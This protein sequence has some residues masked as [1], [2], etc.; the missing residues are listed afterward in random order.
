MSYNRW[1]YGYSNPIKYLDPSGHISYDRNKAITYARKYDGNTPLDLTYHSENGQDYLLFDYSKDGGSL[2]T[3]FASY[4]LWEGGVRDTR[5]D[6]TTVENSNYDPSWWSKEAIRITKDPNDPTI[7]NAIDTRYQVN[8]QTTS[9]SKTQKF[10]DFLMNPTNVNVYVREVIRADYILPKYYN[11]G[12]VTGANDTDWENKLKDAYKS[13]NVTV[14]DLVFYD[15]SDDSPYNQPGWDHVAVIDGWGMQT[16][17][18]EISLFSSIP[19]QSCDWDV[20]KPRVI[21]KSG[22]IIY[23]PGTVTHFGT[24]MDGGRSIDN[25]KSTI[26]SIAVLHLQ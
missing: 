13:R 10:F 7:D 26:K 5:P 11:N 23:E 25:T 14:G 4:V 21:K 3:V 15:Y 20:L 18:S 1:M 22:A 17:N 19:D 8:E 6:P 9:W 12:M 2:C 16:L 24:W